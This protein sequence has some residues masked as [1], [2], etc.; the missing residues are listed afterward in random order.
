MIRFITD[1]IGV[2]CAIS[3]IAYSIIVGRRFPPE[4]GRAVRRGYTFF[5]F[6]TASSE[7]I[8]ISHCDGILSEPAFAALS[9]SA[10][11]AFIVGLSLFYLLISVYFY[12]VIRSIAKASMRHRDLPGVDKQAPQEPQ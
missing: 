9:R 8:I 10:S 1:A 4:I 11:L 6:F 12:G 2:C 7:A 3:V 5:I